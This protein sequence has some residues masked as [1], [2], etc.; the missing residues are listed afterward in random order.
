MDPSSDTKSLE[1]QHE[2]NRLADRLDVPPIAVGLRTNDGL[3]IYIDE[4]GT[5][6]YAYY[7][8]G[9]LNFDQNGSLDDVLYWYVEAI[10]SS[11]AS[12]GDRREAFMYGYQVLHHYNPDWAKR[13]VRDLAAFFRSISK[14]Q[15]IALLPDIGEPL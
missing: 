7:E 11:Q 10:V 1:L 3:N 6:H 13:Y 14:P 15:D 2:L 8:R 12:Y 9:K 4:D 5:Y